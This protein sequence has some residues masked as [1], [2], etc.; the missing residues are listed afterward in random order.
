MTVLIVD[1]SVTIRH[2]VKAYLIKMGITE[3][4]EAANGE[5]A[6]AHLSRIGDPIS[7]IVADLNMPK[8]NGYQLIRFVKGSMPEPQPKIL[9]LTAETSRD[10][11]LLAV[12]EG[13][14]AY[15]IKPLV[16]SKFSEAVRSLLKLSA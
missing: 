3:F 16:E 10:Q 5:V 9:V 12:Q 1:D 15:Q 4:I 11:V 14:D 6:I 7:L 8:V 13:A 2:L